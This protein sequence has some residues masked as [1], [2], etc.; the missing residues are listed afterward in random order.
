MKLNELSGLATTPSID[1]FAA[2]DTTE[3]VN[4]IAGAWSWTMALAA[5]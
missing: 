5:R 4:G 2:N 3:C 1:D